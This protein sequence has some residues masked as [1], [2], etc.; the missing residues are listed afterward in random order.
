MEFAISPDRR[1]TTV[2]RPVYFSGPGLHTGHPCNM[3]V[4]PAPVDYGIRW[5]RID[6]PGEPMIP[7]AVSAVTGTERATTI[8]QGDAYVQTIEHVM[9]ALAGLG[10]DNAIVQIDGPEPPF[11]DG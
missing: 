9:A 4:G 2:A 11:A 1:Q 6:L 7:A 5:Q 10:V 3:S 8:G